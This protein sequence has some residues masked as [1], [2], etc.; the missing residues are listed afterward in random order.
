MET[1]KAGRVG[2][3]R[4]QMSIEIKTRPH[5]GSHQGRHVVG[6]LMGNRIIADEI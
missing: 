5:T 6:S 1:E 2:A 3:I 4:D